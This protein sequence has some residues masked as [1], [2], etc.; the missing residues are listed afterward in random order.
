M[1]D[2]LTNLGF[3]ELLTPQAVEAVIA[4]SDGTILLVVNSVCGC[5]AGSAR[6]GVKLAL[7]K[8]PR[9]DRLCTVFAG[10]EIDA[11]EKA[12]TYFVGYPPSSPQMGLIKNGQLV[13]M[14]ERQNIEGRSAEQVAA[15]L[16]QA[17]AQH[18]ELA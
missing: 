14:M 17:F 10:M 8:T 4:D 6:P 2:E 12:R 9:P 3:E 15:D 16:E 7:E 1:R 11:V 18:C 13:Y 5:A